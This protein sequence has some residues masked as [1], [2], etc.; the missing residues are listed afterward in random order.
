[1]CGLLVEL[2]MRGSDMSFGFSLATRSETVGRAVSR[3]E[4][5]G[6]HSWSSR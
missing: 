2:L 3:D 6:G 5:C 1:M 4:R